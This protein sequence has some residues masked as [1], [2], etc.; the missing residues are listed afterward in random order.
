MKH[1]S[2][3]VTGLAIIL[4]LSACGLTKKDL[5]MS[6]EG[7]KAE[8]VKTNNPLILPPEYNVRPAKK[9]NTNTEKDDTSTNE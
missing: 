1:L 6:R 5:G 4:A 3:I 9:I 2:L 7:P 8:L